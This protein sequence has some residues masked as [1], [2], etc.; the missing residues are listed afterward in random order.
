MALTE[1]YIA[2]GGN[3]GDS[4]SILR[5]ALQ[6]ISTHAQINSMK[7]SRFYQTTP[8]SSL[9]Q[10]SYVN[11]VACFQ[12]ALNAYELLAYLQSIESSLGKIP[13]AKEAPRTIDLDILFFGTER[14]LTSELNVPHPQWFKRLF[15]LVPLSELTNEVY[16]PETLEAG[17]LRRFNLTDLLQT[18]QNIHHEVVVPLTT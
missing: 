4:S 1:V 18:F 6:K 5:A 14:H 10:N 9:H 13:K 8:V 17:K 2:L 16:V 12:T 11:A 7:V 3:I 15:V